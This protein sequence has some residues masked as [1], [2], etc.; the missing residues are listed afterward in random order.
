MAIMAVF[1]AQ[2]MSADQYDEAI[3]KLEEAGEGAPEGRRFHV[4]AVTSGETFSVDVWESE[5][6]LGRFGAV[7]APIVAG[8]GLTPP[9]PEVY[10][11]HDIA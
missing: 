10:P 3:R 2:G 5:E 7:L 9:Q 4:A 1:H 8:L 11:V 6:A